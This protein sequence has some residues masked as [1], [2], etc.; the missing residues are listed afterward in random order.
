[1]KLFPDSKRFLHREKL[2]RLYEKTFNLY[3]R[4]AVRILHSI[5]EAE[6][7]VQSVFVQ[8]QE[9][10]QLFYSL[11]DM[12]EAPAIQYIRKMVY[13]ASHR[14]KA[15]KEKKAGILPPEKD[16]INL[17]L[18]LLEKFP[19][20]EKMILD[21]Y[22]RFHDLTLQKLADLCGI[23]QNKIKKRYLAAKRRMEKELEQYHIRIEWYL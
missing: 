13:S 21:V 5:E 16:H 18:S 15:E 1:M 12:E 11:T 19:P 22:F 17:I 14:Y 7:I 4:E 9:D 10:S 23:H 3:I 8:I 6:D 20:E 2:R